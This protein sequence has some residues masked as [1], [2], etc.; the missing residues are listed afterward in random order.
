MLA[1]GVMQALKEL[2]I[3]MPNDVAVVGYTTFNWHR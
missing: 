2:G 3:D 1:I